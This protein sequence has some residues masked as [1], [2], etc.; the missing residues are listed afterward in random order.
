METHGNMMLQTH[1]IYGI[2]KTCNNAN[3]A[4]L[5]TMLLLR[6]DF[7][8]EHLQGAFAGNCHSIIIGDKNHGTSKS[9]QKDLLDLYIPKLPLNG[10]ES[11]LELLQYTAIRGVH[12]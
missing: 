2:Y 7:F 11:R 5:S 8:R 3:C 9:V 6:P 10:R 4:V 1:K 12:F